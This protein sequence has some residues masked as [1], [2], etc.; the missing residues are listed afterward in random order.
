MSCFWGSSSPWPASCRDWAAAKKVCDEYLRI[1]KYFSRD[2]HNHG[3]V[4]EDPSAWAV[5]QYHD[6]E[7]NEGVVLA[8]RRAESPCDRVQVPLKG[9]PEGAQVVAEHLD[10]GAKTAVKGDLEIVLGNRR[11]SAVVLYRVCR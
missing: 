4:S 9:L 7:T 8:F 6:P 11:S 3:S 5:W 10:T 2:F 1:R